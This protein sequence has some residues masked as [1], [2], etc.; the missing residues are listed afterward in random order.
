[1]LTIASRF[2]P[3]RY[4]KPWTYNHTTTVDDAEEEAANHYEDLLIEPLIRDYIRFQSRL[5]VTAS[6]S[7]HLWTGGLNEP[8]YHVDGSA[9]SGDWGRPQRYVT[10]HLYAPPD[11]P[12]WME[13]SC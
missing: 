2:L 11:S 9:F 7:G 1:M 12:R 13:G 4:L 3:G 8:K 5:Q 6:R 10:F